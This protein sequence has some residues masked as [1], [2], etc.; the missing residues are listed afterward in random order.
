MLFI[1]N[2]IDVKPNIYKAVV[3]RDGTIRVL[4]IGTTFVPPFSFKKIYAIPKSETLELMTTLNKNDYQKLISGKFKITL[5][6][7]ITGNLDKIKLSDLDRVMEY[8]EYGIFGTCFNAFLYKDREEIKKEVL[9]GQ[10][11][12]PATIFCGQFH[13][14][15]Y[16]LIDNI[17]IN[18]DGRLKITELKITSAL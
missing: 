1:P 8:I 10:E 14:Q 4:D 13:P 7:Q 15:S 9:S 6:I 2:I 5:D 16:Q 17:V 12:H 18:W 3:Y 11:M